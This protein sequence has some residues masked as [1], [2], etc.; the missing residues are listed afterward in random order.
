L[1]CS[2]SNLTTW[3]SFRITAGWVF[4]ALH[5]IST[6]PTSHCIQRTYIVFHCSIICEK[7]LCVCVYGGGGGYVGVV[8]EIRFKWRCTL[9]TGKLFSNRNVRLE[10]TRDRRWTTHSCNC[11]RGVST[12]RNLLYRETN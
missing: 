12:S 5:T 6:S 2:K 11:T 1:N 9:V 4:T 7:T 8:K 3:M 10:K